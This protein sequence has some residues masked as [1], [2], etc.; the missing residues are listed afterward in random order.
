M[1]M[2][3]EG[4]RVR[5]GAVRRLLR[6]APRPAPRGGTGRSSGSDWKAAGA[7][8]RRAGRSV[9]PRTRPRGP[10]SRS[11]APPLPHRLRRDPGSRVPAKSLAQAP[12]PEAPGSGQKAASPASASSGSRC[13]KAEGSERPWH[14]AGHRETG[15]A[16]ARLP[17]PVLAASPSLGAQGARLLPGQRGSRRGVRGRRAG[18]GGG[19]WVLSRSSAGREVLLAPP[20]A[21]SRPESSASSFWATSLTRPGR[22]RTSSRPRPSAQAPPAL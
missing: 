18:A 3:A 9:A 17:P 19:S 22:P 7:R 20:A 16:G 15:Q 8:G 21:L 13:P 11:Q 1:K 12:R 14:S 4:A 5:R 2:R 6:C 10:R